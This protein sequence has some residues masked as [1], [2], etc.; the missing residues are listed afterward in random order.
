MKQYLLF[1]RSVL[2]FLLLAVGAGQVMAD[3][4]TPTTYT[5]TFGSVP[6]DGGTV[7]AKV[8]D[9]EIT[10]GSSVLAGSKVTFRKIANTGYEFVGWYYDEACTDKK[11]DNAIFHLEDLSSD[12]SVYAKFEKIYRNI[13]L[14]SSS[15]YTI[16]LISGAPEGRA[17]YGT[18]VTFS[19]TPAAGYFL[20]VIELKDANSNAIAFTKNN[21]GTYSFVM[22]SSHVSIK[23]AVTPTVSGVKGTDYTVA[24][25]GDI[26]ILT[27]G[28]TV[29]GTLSSNLIIKNTENGGTMNITFDN[30]QTLSSDNHW[31]SSIIITNTGGV[32]EIDETTPPNFNIKF[33]GVNAFV[34]SSAPGFIINPSYL[35]DNDHPQLKCFVNFSTE[36]QSVFY[37]GSNNSESKAL[38][39]YKDGNSLYKSSIKI[40]DDTQFDL[41]Y[42]STQTVTGG[43]EPVFTY[44]EIQGTATAFKNFIN[45]C[46]TTFQF[47]KFT[48][49]QKSDTRKAPAGWLTI[50]Y[51][52][53]GTVTN[54]TVYEVFG[55]VMWEEG[56]P[57]M[58]ENRG[59]L[60]R[61]KHLVLTLRDSDNK[62][63]FEAGK[64]YFV[65]KKSGQETLTFVIDENSTH[66]DP[67]MSAKGFIG[68]YATKTMEPES[69][70]LSGSQMAQVRPNST[71]NLIPEYRA[72]FP[73]KDSNNNFLKKV[74]QY[75]ISRDG[76]YLVYGHATGTGG[77]NSG[78]DYGNS[79]STTGETTSKISINDVV[80]LGEE[81]TTQIIN[82]FVEKEVVS[83][84]LYDLMGRKVQTPKK[85]SLYIMNGKKVIY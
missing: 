13:T 16:A 35:E 34:N 28:L 61:L 54:G 15:E 19:V 27:S 80:I 40:A 23:A 14:T 55:R 75:S 37:I 26:T 21:D 18:T 68:V 32:N 77:T 17:E 33:K 9:D 38:K 62:N 65:K 11:A 29:T 31:N 20:K 76:Q 70:F 47:V 51:P 5:V 12:K 30:V 3:E 2:L 63:R 82:N 66:T 49:N 59:E 71:Q 48:M 25:N 58:S 4:E 42:Y 46:K 85:G 10:S 39:D 45:S 74:P 56:D 6:A 73:Y 57:E 24:A 7:T 53:N 60:G 8:G 72:Y 81:E 64:P 41:L 1:L 50:C 79:G 36:G 43:N 78:D 69:F 84:G 52:Y 44:N 83:S 67:I 22:P